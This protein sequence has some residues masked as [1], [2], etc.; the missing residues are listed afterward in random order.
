MT[1]TP[2]PDC[3]CEGECHFCEEYGCWACNEAAKDLREACADEEV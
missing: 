3:T 1:Y 2:D